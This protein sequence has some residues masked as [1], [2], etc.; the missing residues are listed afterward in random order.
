MKN[1]IKNSK[2]HNKN[3]S[4]ISYN[5]N[6]NNN[7]TNNNNYKI[8]RCSLPLLDQR[9]NHS[10][11]KKKNKLCKCKLKMLQHNI[12]KKIENIHNYNILI[13]NCKNNM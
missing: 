12:N 3:I 10:Y 13:N 9:T 7:N 1:N 4:N 6:N 5:N 11:L 8:F 2:L